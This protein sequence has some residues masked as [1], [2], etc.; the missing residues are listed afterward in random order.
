MTGFS[1]ILIGNESLTR[2]CGEVLLQ[3]GHRI[4]ALVT[5]NAAVADWGVAQGL[6]VVSDWAGLGAVDWI[7]SV[8]NLRVIPA[9]VLALARRGAVNFHDGP[10]PERA[11]LNAP[12]WALLDG[13]KEHGIAWHLIAGGVDAG[14]ILE[15][16]RF[17]IAPDDT[18]LTLN[19]RCFEAAVESFPALLT[20]LET[21]A[22][23]RVAQDLTLRRHLHR[24]NDRP[25]GV[26]DAAAGSAAV[27]RLVRAL[28]HG[29]YW[30]PLTTAKISV[31]GRVLNVG[32]AAAVPGSGVAGQVLSAT[33]A[34]L[35]IATSDGAVLLSALTC[36]D[37]GMPVSAEG[38][39]VKAVDAPDY[40]AMTAA[41]A[42]VAA[43][44]PALRAVLR[45][46]Q[47]AV[48]A[49]GQGAQAEWHS[50]AVAGGALAALALARMTGQAAPLLAR[51]VS[52]L[53]GLVTD[54]AP[55]PVEISAPIGGARAAV[56]RSTA[57]G[58][59]CDLLTR[60]A[61][62]AAFAMPQIGLSEFGVPMVGTVVTLSGDALWVDQARLPDP[63]PLLLRLA[64]MVA[65]MAAAGDAVPLREIAAIGVAEREFVL[66]GANATAL[67]HD[68]SLTIPQAFAEQVARSPEATALVCEGASLSYAALDAAANRAAQVLVQMGVGPGTLVGLCAARSLDLVIGALAILKAGG[69]YVPM[70]PAYPA[71]RIALFIED[72][73]CKVIVTQSHLAAT[74]PKHAAQVLSL[75]TDPRIAAA[76]VSA[77]KTTLTP[78]DLAYLIY[79]SGSTGRPK[80][81][82]VEHRNVVNFCAGMDAHLGTAPGT[83]LAVTSLSFDISV[84][85]LFWTLTRGYKVVLTSDENRALV[86]AGPVSGGK[87]IDFSL[88]YWGNDDGIGPKKYELLLEGAKFADQHGFCA[89]WTPERHF[90]AFG[91]PYPNPAVTGAAVAAVTQNIGVRGGSCVMPLHHP[92]RIAEEWAVIDNLTNGRAGIAVASGWH[93]DDF[94]LRPENSPPA[95]KKAMLETADQVRRL[96]RGEKVAFPKP[97]GTMFEVLTQPRPVS[98]ELPL[99]V[100]TAGN[101]ETW[102]EAGSIGANVLTHLLGQTV[103]EVAGKITI[104]HQALRDAG[105][106]PA[107][108]TVT[109]MLHA[110]LA[111][112]RD[113]ARATAKEPMKD[114]LR[115]AAALIKQ[116]AW[117]FPAFK[118][119][120]GVTNP[121]QIDLQSLTAEETDAVLEFAFERYFEDSGLFGTVEDAVARVEQV[122]A[123]GV[124]E[125][126][127]LIDYGIAPSVVL[128]SLKPL[129]EVLRRTNPAPV[130]AGDYSIA[131]QILRHGV[132][133]LQCTPSM[134]RMIAMNPE[135]RAA[136]G[137]VKVLL[138]GGEALPGTLVSDLRGATSARMLNMYGPTET[139]IWSSVEEVAGGEIVVNIGTPLA[140]QQMYVLDPA[141]E[142]VA[143]GVEGDLWIGG[144][145]VTRGYWQRPE[146]TAEKFRANPFAPGRI[147]GTGDLVRRRADGRLDFLGRADG[148]VKLRGYR[149]ELGEI[150]AVLEAQ[151]GVAQAVVL[152]REDQPGDLRLVAY[153]TGSAPEPALRTALAAVLPDHMRPAHYVAL[154]AFPLTPNRKIDRKALLP[155][156]AA[157]AE[158]AP[159]LRLSPVPLVEAQIATVWQRVLGVARVGPKDNFFALGGHSLL[160]VQVHRELR[161]ALSAPKLSITDIFRFPVLEALAAHLGEVPPVAATETRADARAE[162][163]DRRRAMR[164]GRS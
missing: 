19:T 66:H 77:P 64:D 30:N 129:A 142:P 144:D 149:I 97:D 104:Y 65:A 32:A 161:E 78:D 11:G 130:E 20:Q 72:S 143:V 38:I 145:G 89:V 91:G 119:P 68:R 49:S 82:M 162:A 81:V 150:E 36:Q 155:P 125:V 26:I 160:A 164:T 4:D 74:L 51:A 113:E 158:V 151:P 163:M 53:A 45:R 121:M 122:K 58:F 48:L 137:G 123:I 33:A 94:V 47:A 95:N 154:A 70:D 21:G 132:T 41:L 7:L 102:K 106:D 13:A 29:R 42:G 100:T 12:V 57:Q 120:A 17:A 3:R 55:V 88:F 105:H 39:T 80:G 116:Y 117:A 15:A 2:V 140:N 59:A 28:D 133:H 148:Q 135:S 60:D 27:L 153:L 85:E 108:F 99:W 14:D 44:E 157:V 6:R 136:L 62:L 31:G 87:G 110:Y 25:I 1:T 141:G 103:D 52:G 93:P 101:P 23:R 43:A 61:A 152:A 8:A 90:H 118:K 159:P 146:L 9:P 128:E 138:L 79:T 24:R 107:R 37:R 156:R 71:D 54:W 131:G 126:A 124:G 134:A 67:D 35:V 139:T 84:L 10:L 115:S 56:D 92:A 5:V 75:D 18:A 76:P 114:Y 86:S 111:G 98:R 147:Y 34:G 46:G 112:T 50:H 40:A 96:W 109:L 127:C 16:R 22:L 69:A 63:A 83:W 73:A